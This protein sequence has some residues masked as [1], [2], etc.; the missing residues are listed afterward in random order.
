MNML[1]KYCGNNY[2]DEFDN[3]GMV[4]LNNE[5]YKKF[6]T[7]INFFRD[8]IYFKQ[9]SD[10][11][12]GGCLFSCGLNEYIVYNCIDDF[13]RD[14]D[15]VEIS[16]EEEKTLR[17]MFD[18]KT[19]FG[20]VQPID[21]FSTDECMEDVAKIECADAK[22]YNFSQTCTVLN[23]DNKSKKALLTAICEYYNIGNYNYVKVDFNVF[24]KINDDDVFTASQKIMNFFDTDTVF[25]FI[26][27]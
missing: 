11:E 24:L 16:E 14:L 21:F 8:N 9:I 13:L 25:F 26:S 3:Y 22:I 23:L 10:N 1:I 27:W 2:G 4:L 20:Y 12:Y 5:E 18:N 19:Y 6:E 7:N 15:I 17:K